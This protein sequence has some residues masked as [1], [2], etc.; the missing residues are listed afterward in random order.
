MKFYSSLTIAIF[1]V[2][3]GHLCLVVT[4]MTEE[5]FHHNRCESLYFKRQMASSGAFLIWL[6]MKEKSLPFFLH[7]AGKNIRQ[8]Y[9][10]PKKPSLLKSDPIQILDALHKDTGLLL[11][12]LVSQWLARPARES[13]TCLRICRHLSTVT[14]LAGYA[15]S[16]RISTPLACTFLWI[17]NGPPSS[18]PKLLTCWFYVNRIPD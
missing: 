9:P 12:E 15:A 11:S 1:Q 6:K 7:W 3:S 2:F 14:L 4:I 17:N 8:W 18:F 10:S 5:Y 16:T 13:C